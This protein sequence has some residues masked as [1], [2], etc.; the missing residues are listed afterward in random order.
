VYVPFA[1]SVLDYLSDEKIDQVA[2]SLENATIG[3]IY[4][5]IRT[6]RDEVQSHSEG[7]SEE[8]VDRVTARAIEKYQALLA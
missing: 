1:R 7:L 4:D 2:R 5:Y 8:L 6:I 3:D